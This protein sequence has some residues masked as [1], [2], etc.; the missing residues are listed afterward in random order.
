M[1]ALVNLPDCAVHAL[2]RGKPAGN[3]WPP[4]SEP[5]RRMPEDRAPTSGFLPARGVNAAIAQA[6]ACFLTPEA[7]L[8]A[9]RQLPGR[10]GVRTSDS[11][12]A[13]PPSRQ[14]WGKASR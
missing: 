11:M 14:P 10:Q 3:A 12:Q 1:F 8:H 13:Q 4:F 6:L 2:S 5:D 7:H 9:S